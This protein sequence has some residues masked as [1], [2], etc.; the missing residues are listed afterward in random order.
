MPVIYNGPGPQE[1]IDRRLRNSGVGHDSKHSSYMADVTHESYPNRVH[2]NIHYSANRQ[3][4]DVKDGQDL[5]HKQRGDHLG[6][7]HGRPH[8]VSKRGD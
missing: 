6:N 8:G 4:G 3:H 2:T 7:L 5:F 1:R